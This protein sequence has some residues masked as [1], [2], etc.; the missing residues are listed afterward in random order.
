[1]QRNLHELSNTVHD[2]LIL[3]GGIYGAAATWDAALRGL[4]VALLEKGDWGGA[5]SS[6]SLKIIHGG[7]RYLQHADFKRMR[8][9]I[10]ERMVLMRIAPHL[11]H[12]LPCVMPTYGHA[13][14]GKEIM[15]VAMFMN[16]LIGFDRNGLS[17]PQ[18]HLPA[19]RVISKRECLEL[20]PGLEENGLTGGATW[21]DCQVY[22]SERMLLSYLHAAAQNGAQFANYV[23]VT[24]FITKDNRVLGVQARDVLT[25]NDFEI[26]ARL[27]INNSGPWVN[28]TLGLLQNESAGR[29]VLLSKAMNLILRRQIFPKFA[30]GVPS[31]FEFKDSDALINKGSRLLFIRPWRGRSMVGTTHVPYHGEPKDFH[32]TENDIQEFID[33]VSAAYPAANLSRADVAFFNGG[34]LPMEGVNPRS[35]DVRLVKHY[36]VRDHEREHGL[37]GLLT[38]V[39]VKYTTA[40]DVAQK[41]IDLAMQKL[42][43]PFKPSVG[44]VTPVYGGK[45]ARFEEF[46]Q[47]EMRRKPHG[48]AQ[49]LVKHLIYNH[50]ATYSE[51]FKHAAEN[52][53]W[54]QPLGSNTEVL[55]A[56]VIHGTR[57]EMA[58]KLADVVMRRTELGSAGHPGAEALQACAQLM[59]KELGWD[60]ARAN[61][62]IAETEAVFVPAKG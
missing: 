5:T 53:A 27:V 6:N 15:A 17:D 44:A 57:E 23:E 46:L 49:N 42:V 59:A 34:L 16:D 47:S 41:S 51:I 24:G 35:G 60:A 39:G 45:I 4:S 3:G 56:E 43:V 8:E 11:V 2:I 52:S 61:Q 30:V 38:V 58:L 21:Y 54:L 18:K 33:E 12:P 7:L 28:Q 37:A 26:R 22:N 9:S 62:E 10:R 31:K 32:V 50:G 36:I 20:I 29:K 48:L 1:M 14:K 19:G 25:Q 13:M 55:Q 40:R